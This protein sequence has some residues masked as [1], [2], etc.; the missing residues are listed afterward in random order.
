MLSIEIV[1]DGSAH[2]PENMSTAP[3]G[4]EFC[5][6][7][8]YDYKVFVNSKLVGKGRIEDHNRLTGW[9]GLINCLEEAVNG[10]RFEKD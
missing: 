5:I 1:N 6:V 10:G 8:N 4:Q 3:D 7:G 2:I 9:E